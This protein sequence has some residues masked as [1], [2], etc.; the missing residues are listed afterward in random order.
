MHSSEWSDL[1]QPA[2][3]I[4]EA[5]TAAVAAAGDTD[6]ESYQ[7]ATARLAGQHAEQVGIVAGETVR[8]LLEERYPDGLT[9][10]DLRAVLTGCAAAAGW[11]PEFDPTVAMTL[12][13]GALGV[14]EADGEPLPLAAAE[15]AG[16]GP[17]LIAE[18]ATG[19]PHPLGSYLRAALA[20]IART[21]TM[22]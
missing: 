16:H 8:L 14:H 4:A 11:Y 10:D 3:G 2:R 7:L 20:E 18:L 15:V 19:A 22:D 9:G 21:E 17:L 6:A 12:I 1:P 5:T 13:A